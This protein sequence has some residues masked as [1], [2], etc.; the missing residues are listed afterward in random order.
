MYPLIGIAGPPRLPGDA[1]SVLSDALA[2]VI[3]NPEV[4]ARIEKIG[5]IPIYMS[6]QQFRAA[7][8]GM[9]KAVVEHK[10]VFEEKK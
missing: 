1:S 8:E 3:K 2:R 4:M 5:T 9:Y 6:D 7:A 10:D